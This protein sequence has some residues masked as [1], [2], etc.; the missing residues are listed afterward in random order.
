M[1][2]TI[3]HLQKYAGMN[4][5]H[6]CPQCEHKGEFTLYVDAQ[7]RPIAP[8]VGRCNRERCSYHLSP[9]EYFKQNPTGKPDYSTWKQPE[10]VKV[11][12]VSYLP[13]SLIRPDTHR[14]ENNL[15]RFMAKEFGKEAATL[16]FDTYHVG[17][18]RHWRNT[19]GLA[20]SFPQV[21]ELGQVRQIKV[22]AYNPATGKRMKKQDAAKLWIDREEKY[23]P[24][25]RSIDK[26]WFAGKSILK[27]QE[28][29]LQQTFF[30]CHLIK[31][32]SR[33]GIVESE[34]S[35][36][37]CSILM[38]DITW[39]ATGG[40][41]G[42]KWTESTVFKPLVG[43][44]IVLYPDSGMFAKWQEKAVIL[45]SGRVDV[46]VSRVCEGLL[47]NTDIADVLLRERHIEK[48]MTIGEVL[49]YAKEIGVI[50]RIKIN[51]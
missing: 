16:A 24:D 32:A 5:R 17:T 43:K 19:D 1:S 47:D 18:S 37:I 4:T 12:P 42:C 51:V 20:T 33:V 25:T 40:C 34:K 45:R 6:T 49:A 44:R 29:N 7:D 36:L 39:I 15:F 23:V 3:Y 8:E 10:P 41:N 9:S 14:S 30:G 2:E 13:S 38:P 26:I 31:D 22:M 50:N 35:A 48:G 11:V 27:N 46:T 21:D 28:A